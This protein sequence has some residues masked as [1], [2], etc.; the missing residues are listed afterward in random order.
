MA[1]FSVTYTAKRELTGGHTFNSVQTLALDLKILD[2]VFVIDGSQVLTPSNASGSINSITTTYDVETKM[3]D[4]ST[5]DLFTEFL[6]SCMAS[7]MFTVSIQGAASRNAQLIFQRN[8]KASKA[9]VK[10]RYRF[11][12]RVY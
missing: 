2:R 11:K 5:L 10:F 3:M 6:L 4:D 8:L 9:G 7:E 1:D 12:I